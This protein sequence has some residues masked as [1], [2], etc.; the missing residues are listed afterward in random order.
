MK[1]LDEQTD[2]RQKLQ[3]ILRLD[4]AV[5]LVWKNAPGWTLVNLV[6]VL[7]QGLLPLAT[8]YVTKRIVDGVAAGLSAADKVAA[9]RPV[10]S[11]ILLAAGVAIL[12]ALCRSLAELAAETQSM[13][14]T[15][16]VSDILHAQSVVVDLE[17][18]ENA[19]YYDTLHRAQQEAPY[20]PTQI[21]HGLHHSFKS[22]FPARRI[23]VFRR[24]VHTHLGS[25]IAHFDQLLR[26]GLVY[27]GAI[28]INLEE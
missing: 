12:S 1:H 16:A 22:S 13:L 3:Q 6:L 7:I 8:L 10:L 25:D 2:L 26:R 18:Y 24:A 11:W 19:N 5:A 23:R 14:V 20:R 9:F 28:G 21:V 17:Y 27:K 15:D 4:R